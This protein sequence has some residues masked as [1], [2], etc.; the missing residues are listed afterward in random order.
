MFRP[1]Q[2]KVSAPVQPRRGGGKP[3]LAGRAEVLLRYLAAWL[4][5]FFVLLCIVG[6]P[7][8]LLVTSLH[9]LGEPARNLVEK[10]LS[11]KF[12]TV[13]L[14]RLL[15][16]PTN[17]FIIENL[18]MYDTTS[19]HRLVV[20]ADRI[21]ISFN[22]EALSRGELS[23]ERI[24]LRDATLDIPLGPEEEPRLRLDH[25][26]ATLLCTPDQIRVSAS[27]FQ[28]A[29][30]RVVVS[31]NF[32]N[33]KL[34]SPKPVSTTGPGNMALTI[35][36]IRKQLS[37][38][39]W[40]SGAPVLSL[41]AG[42]DLAN[43]ETLRIDHAALRGGAGSW[44]GIAFR[45]LSL[46]LRYAD[47]LL[48]LEKAMIEDRSGI[49]QAVGRADFRGNKASVEFSGA[50]DAG[51]LP[52]LLAPEKAGDWNWIDPVRL[53]GAFSAGWGDGPAA[54]EG[55]ALL[56]S[57]RFTYRGVAL[58]SLSGGVA[59]RGGKTLIRDLHV[60]GAPGSLDAD[61]M[62]APGDNRVRFQAALYPA[63]LAPAVGG[64]AAQNLSSMD[65]KDPLRISFEG[66]APGRD[67]L[68][69]KG[70]GT[71]ECGRAS[72]HGAGMDSLNASVQVAAGAAA[73]RNITVKMGEGTGH[74]DFVYDYQNWEGRL[75]AIRSTLDPVRLMTWIDPR[76]ADSLK[77]YR[78]RKPPDLKVSGKVGL[79]N[80]DKNDLRIE[81]NAPTGLGYTLIGKDLPFGATSGSVHLKK[82]SLTIDLPRSRLF[83]G[84]VSL[85][86]E[87]SVS[88]DDHSY[89]ATV[90]LEDVDFQTLTKVYFDYGE[91][92]GSLTADYAFRAV[93]GNDLAMT[94]RGNLV[95]KNGNVLAMPVMGPFSALLNDVV[96]GLGYQPARKA[97]ADFTVENGIINTRDLLIQGSGFSM[98]GNGRI[99]YLED[100]ME[101][102]MRLNA[103]GLPGIV[104]FPVSKILEYESVGSAKHPK[105]R[106]K[107]LPKIPSRETAPVTP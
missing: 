53:N 5:G 12:Y 39:Q 102:N 73:F 48:I 30:I 11:G 94:G 88:P 89:G 50:F 49:L 24:F 9:G 44:H 16:S 35:D 91:S 28:I 84:D 1:A 81:L 6:T 46:D 33:P 27:S 90:H 79:R 61:L 64:V 17:G 29:G 36:S 100:K 7:V 38:V 65:F 13:G 23:L 10:K 107:I 8:F 105:W 63:R 71:L 85:R 82:Q 67:P 37:S 83:G 32:L 56:A 59:Q 34:F 15:F 98:I 19:S 57:G 104:L 101:M 54:I 97:T 78:F 41:R 75:S 47:R 26:T 95:I 55:N 45:Q 18:R 43:V 72:M 14:G 22:F 74:G 2:R 68:Q 66:D 51:A 77:A 42:G 106:P 92:Q 60:S 4:F 20:S 103:Q 76:I 31:G 69:L 25:V 70:S 99:H 3:V 62:I 52:L 86:A 87:V 96:P 21:S 93:T 40:G 80:P 58:D